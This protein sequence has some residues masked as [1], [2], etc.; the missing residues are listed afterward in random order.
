MQ[1]HLGIKYSIDPRRIRYRDNQ[2][3]CLSIASEGFS[4]AEICSRL[5]GGEGRV[6]RQLE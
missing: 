5:K 2:T 3:I 6:L 4:N 1:I